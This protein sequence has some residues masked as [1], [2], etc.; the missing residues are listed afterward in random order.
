MMMASVR[1]L[2]RGGNL[3]LILVFCLVLPLAAGGWWRFFSGYE[4]PRV[5][6]KVGRGQAVAASNGWAR[7]AEKDATGVEE[8]EK[9]TPRAEPRAEPRAGKETHL[10][11]RTTSTG[12]GPTAG[13]DKSLS[14]EDR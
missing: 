10:L 7:R 6:V 3:A 11:A 4:H 14:G 13:Q 9:G 1:D 5:T 2:V 12:T 8:V